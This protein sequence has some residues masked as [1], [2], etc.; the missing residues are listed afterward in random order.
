MRAGCPLIACCAFAAWVLAGCAKPFDPDAPEFRYL[1]KTPPTPTL[2]CG[3]DSL[4]VCARLTGDKSLQLADLERQLQ[5]GPRG[6]SLDS[7]VEV[8]KANCLE[9][10][11]YDMPAEGVG[12]LPLPAICHVNDN[13][14]I[15][16]R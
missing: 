14:Y 5:V 2:S 15:A 3:A 1:Y 11:A 12:R 4:Y 9:A 16:V 6:V 10:T 8:A 7:L 13:H